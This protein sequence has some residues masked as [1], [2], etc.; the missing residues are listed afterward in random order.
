MG[1]RWMNKYIFDIYGINDIPK[2]NSPAIQ[3]LEEHASLQELSPLRHPTEHSYAV[4]NQS[5]K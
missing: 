5:S 1:L 3:P 4:W 2:N